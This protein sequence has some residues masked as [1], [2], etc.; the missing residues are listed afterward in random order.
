MKK[1]ILS[2]MAFSIVAMTIVGCKK[3]KDETVP[4][5]TGSATVEGYVKANLNMRNDT[6]PNGT[7]MV[8]KEGIPTSVVLTF[9]ID[10][11][12]LEK[13]PDPMYTYNMIKKTTS[14][15]GSGHYSIS[16]PTPMSSNT[17]N[18]E[19]NI[20]DFDY[21]PII[22]SSA[23]TDSAA[24]RQVYTAPAQGFSIYNGGKTIVDY[25]Y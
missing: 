23:N 2:L 10:S 8:M 22:T 6:L 24:A 7:P 1:T 15:D 5:T 9:V 3:D 11:R 25:N 12:D 19:M 4:S 14:V 21:K 13:N 18:G 16:L 17:I 20:S